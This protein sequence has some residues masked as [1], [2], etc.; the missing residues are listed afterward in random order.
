MKLKSIFWLV[1]LALLW[2]V[3]FLFVKVAVQDIPPLTLV[4]AR[5]G[6]AALILYLI[7]RAQNRPLPAFGSTWL[8]CAVVGL[9]YNAVPYALLA[10]AQQYIDSALAA[11]F[12]GATPL[13]TMALAHWFTLDDHF[14]PAKI[15][16][17]VLGF[18]GLVIL[19][20][21][22]IV[23][24]VEVTSL[25]LLAALAAAAS[26]GGAIVYARQTVRN[27]PPLA[28]PT[29]QLTSAALFLLPLSLAIER[30][31]TLPWP[32]WT[33][34]ESL[35]VLAIFSTALAFFL[36]YRAMETSSATT[37]AMVT[38][39]VPVVATIVGVVVLNEQLAWSAYLGFV[40]IILG[41]VT[42]N[43]LFN[44]AH[45]RGAPFWARARSVKT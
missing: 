17:I 37:L 19:L 27:L 44:G 39:L 15:S 16:G 34:L 1:S 12:I 41:I 13:F 5:V 7:M 18:G 38:Y 43:G 25:G 3:A 33:A 24:G 42:V 11:M 29:I 10:W 4:T 36:Y 31:F 22:E 21:P 6:S 23:G 40:L 28:G 14:T 9:L 35:M 30:P 8:H 2:G 45:L 32:S 26:Y 20:A